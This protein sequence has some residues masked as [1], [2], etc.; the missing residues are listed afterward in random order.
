MATGAA[1]SLEKK[2][3]NWTARPTGNRT[4]IVEVSVD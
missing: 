4:Y 1:A 3:A 2:N